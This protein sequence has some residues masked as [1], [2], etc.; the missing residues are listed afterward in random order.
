M[1]RLDGTGPRGE[2]AETGRGMGKC[3]DKPR[4]RCFGFR[5]RK[6]NPSDVSELEKEREL[7]KEELSQIE[8]QI[9]DLKK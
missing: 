7:L 2:G 4:G 9:A 5:L 3:T 1:P 6:E 8:S